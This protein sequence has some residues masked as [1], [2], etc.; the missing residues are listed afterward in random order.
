MTLW[1]TSTNSALNVCIFVFE[2]LARQLFSLEMI[3]L[4][5]LVFTAMI[6]NDDVR[7]LGCPLVRVATTGVIS[8]VIALII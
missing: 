7:I 3:L 1:F 4:H 6:I 8:L 5:H 2:V